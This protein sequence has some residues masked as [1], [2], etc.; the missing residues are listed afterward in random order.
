M[1][2]P[3]TS[4]A[5]ASQRSRSRIKRSEMAALSFLV[6]DL[7]R[8]HVSDTKS[9]LL[10]SVVQQS[11][12]PI[13]SITSEGLI[14]T[15]N[16][17]CEKLYGY[18][19][20]E[21]IG[22]PLSMIVPES[23]REESR[24]MFLKV[25]RGEMVVFETLRQRRD[26][27][28]VD[29]SISGA[30]LRDNQGL[31]VGICSIHRDIA[32]QRQHEKQLRLVMRE[33]AH[34]SKNL[35]AIIISMATQTARHSANITDFTTRFTQRLLGL[36][37]SHDLLI[38]ENWRGAPLRALI[39]S[40]LEPFIG[41]DTSRVILNGSDV[42]VDPKAAQNLGL[43]LHELATNASKYG[44]LSQPSG[45]IFISWEKTAEGNFTVSW[46]ESGGPNGVAPTH[47]GFGQAVLERLAA[48]A[49]EG[50]AQLEF[51]PQGVHWR[52]EMPAE[53]LVEASSEAKN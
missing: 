14:S 41:G 26:G 37:H 30:P 18:A 22:R 29:V 44:A 15:W 47:R 42:I 53:Y 2:N 9:A 27:S 13:L 38:Q 5:G 52:M 39:N 21:A 20:D 8:H 10:A 28:L 34:R 35:L 46:R 4:Q 11:Y 43:A 3:I 12:D 25:I 49:L 1:Y 16:P 19:R 32:I 36:A 33:L 50:H 6:R 7:H 51:T 48:Q 45:R 17:A 40:H 23:R 24:S 31:I